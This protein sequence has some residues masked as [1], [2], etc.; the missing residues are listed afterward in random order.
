M[1]R[2]KDRIETTKGISMKSPEYNTVI[3]LIKEHSSIF[4]F[5]LDNLLNKL[6]NQN[7]VDLKEILEDM[8]EA[9]R[10]EGYD[11]GYQDGKHDGYDRGWTD[12]KDDT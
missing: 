6:D 11:D 7:L 12:A 5:P 1:S 10:T 8:Y 3:K 4:Y 9:G 2:F